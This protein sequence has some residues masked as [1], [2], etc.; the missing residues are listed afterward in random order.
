MDPQKN[1][2]SLCH[3]RP[4][5]NMDGHTRYCLAAMASKNAL[6]IPQPPISKTLALRPLSN[7][8]DPPQ[9]Q[10]LTV[11]PVVL[12]EF[13]DRISP[14]ICRLFHMLYMPESGPSLLQHTENVRLGRICRLGYRFSM[15]SSSTTFALIPTSSSASFHSRRQATLR[16]STS[17]YFHV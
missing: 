1:S 14:P 15:S 16:A 6:S 17:V 11:A 4:Q 12:A 3:V 9:L 5:W 7:R 2:L 8:P 10:L 13:S